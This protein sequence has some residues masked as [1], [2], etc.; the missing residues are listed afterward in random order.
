MSTSAQLKVE[1]L[2]AAIDKVTSPLDAMKAASKRLNGELS[3]TTSELKGL[4]RQQNLLSRFSQM[5]TDSREK[6][7]QMREEQ[8]NIKGL[9]SKQKE[10]TNTVTRYKSTLRDELSE[11]IRAKA[12]VNR[13]VKLSQMTE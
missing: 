3:N 1:L 10:L 6:I 12:V 2:L 11:Q 7:K 13:T 9:V 8:A 5:K 4:E